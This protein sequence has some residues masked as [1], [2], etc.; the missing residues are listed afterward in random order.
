MIQL[1]LTFSDENGNFPTCDSDK[2]CIWQFNFRE[3]D[4]SSDNFAHD[5]IELLRQSGIDFAKNNQ[6][7]V[8]SR[9]FANLL[10]SSGVVLN[11]SVH[12]VMFHGVYD[13]G[14]L[15]KLLSFHDLPETQNGF[16]E[17]ISVY[18]PR[19]YDIKHLMKF[20]NGLRG[21]LNMLAELLEVERVGIRHQA[22][23]DSLL[24]SRTFLKLHQDFFNGSTE[25]YS[26]V[27][28]GFGVENGQ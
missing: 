1:G 16:F 9:R 23:S 10:M 13:F 28:F 11:E 6:D 26:G 24:T 7:G 2:Y 22:G 4:L 18:F 27:F 15:L 20:C 21:G 5:S 3:F 17:M 12:W 25:K 14:Y 19:F 8:D